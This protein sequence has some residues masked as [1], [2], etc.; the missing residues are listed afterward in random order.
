[1]VFIG[2]GVKNIGTSDAPIWAPN[3]VIVN[4]ETYWKS[5]ANNT[6]EPFIYDASFIKLRELNLSYNVPSRLLEKSPVRA[7]SVSVYGRN[8]FILYK[9]VR[10][11]DPESNYSNGNGQGFEYGSLPSRRTFGVSLNIKF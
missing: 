8:L 4:P 11:I 10:N 2:N 5:V 7:A 9:S 6:P 3:D 1:M